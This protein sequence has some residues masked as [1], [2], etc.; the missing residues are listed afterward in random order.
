MTRPLLLETDEIPNPPCTTETNR[1]PATSKNHDRPNRLSLGQ[2]VGLG[3]EYPR[4]K[5]STLPFQEFT[6]MVSRSEPK[7]VAVAHIYPTS[8]SVVHH[9]L[10]LVVQHV[11]NFDVF[12]WFL[13]FTKAGPQMSI[14]ATPYHPKR[15]SKDVHIIC[16]IQ[17]SFEACSTTLFFYQVPKKSIELSNKN[18]ACR[19]SPGAFLS[20][21]WRHEKSKLCANGRTGQ[22]RILCSCSRPPL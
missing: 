9:A 1:N 14:S 22:P 15:C 16:N 10:N 18:S 8:C 21:P 20:R 5:G 13:N 3:R 19:T 4:A 2:A 7:K 6:A 12:I 11:L 17:G